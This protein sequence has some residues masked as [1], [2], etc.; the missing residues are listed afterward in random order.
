MLLLAERSE[1]SLRTILV[2][3]LQ[4]SP[5]KYTARK[6]MYFFSENDILATM[7]LVVTQEVMCNGYESVKV[8]GYHEVGMVSNNT[9]LP[10]P[11]PTNAQELFTTL[12]TIAFCRLYRLLVAQEMPWVYLTHSEL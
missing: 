11:S 9:F 4:S 5:H 7:W 3:E 6:Y 8:T 10:F 2:V 1:K 12:K